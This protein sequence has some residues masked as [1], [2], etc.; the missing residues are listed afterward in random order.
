MPNYKCHKCNKIF[1]QKGHLLYHLNRKRACDI[2][3]ITLQQTVPHLSAQNI[4]SK[5]AA[6]ECKYC[7]KTFARSDSLKRHV[8]SFCKEKDKK[9]INDDI[10][11]QLKQL[12]DT[13][14]LQNEKIKQLEEECKKQKN[15]NNQ[16]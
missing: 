11:I 9:P 8:T 12:K 2:E 1:K 7:N 14:A 5:I 13:L 15:N 6:N 3:F 4:E 10:L 16:Q